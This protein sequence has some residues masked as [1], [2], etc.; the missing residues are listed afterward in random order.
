MFAD[1]SEE[2]TK[3]HEKEIQEVYFFLFS[4]LLYLDFS[5]AAEP[6]AGESHLHVNC[7]LIVSWQLM[8]FSL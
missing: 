4:S 1:T 7:A 6:F 8:M 2:K 5:A 3:V